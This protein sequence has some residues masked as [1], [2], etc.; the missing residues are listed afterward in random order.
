MI[1]R[2]RRTP[3][4]SSL[5]RL[6]TETSELVGRLL[7]ENRTLRAENDRLARE[8]ERLSAGWDEIR[9]LA[10]LAPP[11]RRQRRPPR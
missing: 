6:A 4:G 5:E 3:V 1:R 10:R 9:R 2:T 8:V 7:R 11:Q